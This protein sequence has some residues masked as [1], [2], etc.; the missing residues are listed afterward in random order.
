[1]FS[2]ATMSGMESVLSAVVAVVGTLLGSVATYW[3]QRSS[4]ERQERVAQAQ[5][6]RAE[7]LAVYTEFAAAVTD[8][9][10]AAYDRWH[11][12]QEGAQ[13]RAF[14]DARDGYYRQYAEA[15]NAQLKLARCV[16]DGCLSPA[17]LTA[18]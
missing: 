17:R 18:G 4:A 9:R 14:A 1:M 6:H 10:R 13:D 15:R 16:C 11:R 12:Y 7:R 2:G 5:R 3:F 8:L